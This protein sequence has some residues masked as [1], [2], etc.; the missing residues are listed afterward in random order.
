MNM[1][2]PNLYQL[3]VDTHD[4]TIIYAMPESYRLSLPDL[5]TWVENKLFYGSLPEGFPIRN[6]DSQKFVLSEGKVLA[7]KDEVREGVALL[8]VKYWAIDQVL[9]IINGQRFAVTNK[10]LMQDRIYEAKVE[11]A[12]LILARQDE[13][14]RKSHFETSCP[15]LYAESEDKGLSLNVVA[16]TVMV[17]YE[18]QMSRLKKTEIMRMA[19]TNKIANAETEEQVR[20]L[21]K[22]VKLYFYTR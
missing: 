5:R 13:E 1:G 6:L 14:L 20:A 12:R 8:N 17:A 18:E 10:L 21:L 2:A 19:I 22:D 9:M 11:E 16:K 7:R 3:A 15:M 4:N